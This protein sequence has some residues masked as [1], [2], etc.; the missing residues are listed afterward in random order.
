MTENK[1]IANLLRKRRNVALLVGVCLLLVATYVLYPIIWPRQNNVVDVMEES[2]I[3]RKPVVLFDAS[4][5]Q[6]WSLWDTG[7][8]GYS[9]LALLLRENG[10]TPVWS[11]RPLVEAISSLYEGDIL[12]LIPAHYAYYSDEEV[13]AIENFVEDGGGLL[14]LSEHDNVFGI[15]EFQNKIGRVFGFVTIYGIDY[16]LENDL[17]NT[18]GNRPYWFK[19]SCPFFQISNIG[20]FSVGCVNLSQGAKPLIVTGGTTTPPNAV[21]AGYVERGKGRVIYI[22]DSHFLWNGD[23]IK[24]GPGKYIGI[25]YG[26]NREFILKVLEWLSSKNS[27]E[28]YEANII[29]PQYDLIS[30][31]KNSTLKIDVVINSRTDIHIVS[32]GG[33][34][35][36]GK[37]E[38][39][40]FLGNLTINIY[41]RS[42]GNVSINSANS[43]EKVYIV[44]SEEKKRATILIDESHG[45]RGVSDGASGLYLFARQL[46]KSGLYTYATANKNALNYSVY[47]AVIIANPLISYAGNEIRE[48]TKAKKIVLFAE[49]YSENIGAIAYIRKNVLGHN[50]TPEMGE[51]CYIGAISKQ[52]GINVTYYTIYDDI[53]NLGQR[54]FVP[55]TLNS[56]GEKLVFYCGCI[57]T[58]GEPVF[59]ASDSAWGEAITDSMLNST[60]VEA[61]YNPDLDTR[62]VCGGC[63]TEK[64]LV[65][66]DVD[67]ITNDH[68]GEGG[69]DVA[70]RL[71]K[72]LIFGH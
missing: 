6:V 7:L 4:H 15:G 62:Y 27:A 1:P 71:I 38:Y 19:V 43:C 55:M 52:F 57:V 30:C 54:T 37:T 36:L 12:V 72:T 11:T 45:C 21:V 29:V 23:E 48:I 42:D 9:E 26:N 40:S 58:G 64:T 16:V 17:N 24:N 33:V 28:G 41:V 65:I 60:D 50:T 32:E 3:V 5:G 70:Q 31:E 18:I 44:C 39:D 22:S 61:R 46:T 14:I 56:S 49:P 25:K 20:L 67:I 13:D 69:G 59:W 51:P 47:D 63:K 35:V 66:G 8:V 53:N 34:E 2:H 10:Y 68:I